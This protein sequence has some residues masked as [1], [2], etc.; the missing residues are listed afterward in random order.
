[1]RWLWTLLAAVVAVVCAP[2][3]AHAG[4]AVRVVVRDVSG[5]GAPSA[6]NALVRMLTAEADVHVVSRAYFAKVAGRLDLSPKDAS[7]QKRLQRTLSV[8]AVIHGDVTES[9]AGVTLS[10]KFRGA[11]TDVVESQEISATTRRELAKKIEAEGW[12][13]LGPSIRDAAVPKPTQKRLVLLEVSGAKSG[14][15]RAAIEKAFEKS[16]SLLLVPE[17]EAADAKPSEARKP[18]ERALVAAA[19]GATALLSAEVQGAR[20]MKLKVVV[21]NGKNADELGDLELKG[22]TAAL[23]ARSISAQLAKMVGPI[24]EGAEPPIPPREEPEDEPEDEAPPAAKPSSRPSP[25]EAT[26]AFGIGTRNYRYSD[27]LF[28]ALRAYKM[29]PTPLASLATRWYPA[30]HFTGGAAAH[31][32]IAASFE[33]AFLIESRANGES[34]DTSARQWLLGLHGRLPLDSLELGADIGLGNHS[35]EVDDDPARPLVPDVSYQFVRLGIDARYRTSSWLL[36]GAIGYRHVTD[37]GAISTD[38]WFPR[39]SVAGLDAGAHVGLGVSEGLHLLVGVLYRRYGF[40]MNPEPGDPHVAG[41]ALDS[42]IS[43]WAGVGGEL[44]GKGP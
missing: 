8:A 1:M 12:E 30:A 13:L 34:Y 37:A 9:D 11:G 19:L 6:R 3:A 32:G 44:P 25:L 2:T 26:L 41:G 29:G 17:S 10:V 27:D 35:F 42:Y 16:E 22:A 23:L 4:D 18:K 5:D 20:P 40:S 24:V 33:Q 15:V 21:L 39:L 28:S 7:A 43:G 38:E 31:V 36:A 14:A